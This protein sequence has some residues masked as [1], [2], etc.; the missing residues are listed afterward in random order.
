MA[1]CHLKQ[2]V[3]S[4]LSLA[5]I[6]RTKACDLCYNKEIKCDVKKPRCSHRVV[7]DVECTYTARRKTV[8]KKE[9]SHRRKEDLQVRLDRLEAQLR[10]VS[11]KAD[12]LESLA[13]QDPTAHQLLVSMHKDSR[14]PGNS[15]H[16]ISIDFPPLEEV[17]LIMRNILQH[18]IRSSR[19]FILAHYCHARE[20]RPPGR[21]SM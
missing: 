2:L 10:S 11:E 6:P 19:S 20:K 17:L 16:H 21:Q 18:L 13:M 3:L 5:P 12:K 7:Y 9:S 4:L 15:P 8:P 14:R 1:P